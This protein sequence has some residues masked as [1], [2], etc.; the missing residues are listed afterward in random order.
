MGF[1]VRIFASRIKGGSKMSK[2]ALKCAVP[3]MLVLGLLLLNSCTGTPRWVQDAGRDMDVAAK[4]LEEWGTASISSPL[5]VEPA[6]NFKFKLD[7][8][9]EKLYESAR[10]EASASES[11]FS[12][13]LQLFIISMKAGQDKP[14]AKEEAKDK[15]EPPAKKEEP[16]LSN[17]LP[18]AENIRTPSRSAMVTAWGDKMTLEVLKLFSDPQTAARF[19]NH[20]VVFCTTMVSVRPG[21]LT[22]NNYAADVH[23]RTCYSFEKARKAVVENFLADQKWPAGI[24]RKVADDCMLE[25]INVPE[26][27]RNAKPSELNDLPDDVKEPAEVLEAPLAAAITPM[28]FLQVIEK[29][30][31][32]EKK[33]EF[34]LDI[35]AVFRLLGRQAEAG[36]YEKLANET[37]SGARS[38]TDIGTVIPYSTS[39]G[40]FG[41]KVCPRFV[42]GGGYILDNQSFP[43]MVI[44]GLVKEEIRPRIRIEENGRWAVVEPHLKFVQSYRWLPLNFSGERL[45]EQERLE[46]SYLLRL[47]EASIP[48]TSHELVAEKLAAASALRVL[49]LISSDATS[50]KD[51]NGKERELGWISDKIETAV[52]PGMAARMRDRNYQPLCS[53]RE[54]VQYLG[55]L[56]TIKDWSMFHNYTEGAGTDA[57]LRRAEKTLSEARVLHQRAGHEVEKCIKSVINSWPEIDSTGVGELVKERRKELGYKTCGTCLTMPLPLEFMQK[58]AEDKTQRLRTR[59]AQQQQPSVKPAAQPAATSTSAAPKPAAAPASTAVQQAATTPAAT[60]PAATTPKPAAQP[61]IEK[62][63]YSAPIIGIAGCVLVFGFLIYMGYRILRVRRDNITAESRE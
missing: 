20:Q 32:S 4:G 11:L 57:E 50:L 51:F 49:A 3:F 44:L 53:M 45:G 6:E 7:I 35:S 39:G 23:I 30:S 34:I 42:A 24:R 22:G 2:G 8:S 17:T 5:L 25:N 14:A 12:K 46:W 60:Q 61:P 18:N 58:P 62:L 52:M 21:Q 10:T 63:G 27:V 33:A 13:L 40:L 19:M 1:A 28:N 54:M 36:L 47:A 31:N 29:L 43:A 41:F 38:R 59:P 37:R 55:S 26:D 9:D 16:S 48:P 56:K 15:K